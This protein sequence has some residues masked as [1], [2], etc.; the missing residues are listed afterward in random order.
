VSI[1]TMLFDCT[2]GHALFIDN[3]HRVF[4][5]SDVE[6]NSK[7]QMSI[8]LKEKADTP[9]LQVHDREDEAFIR[10]LTKQILGRWYADSI[11]ND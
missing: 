8:S 2:A 3:P 11:L 1:A 6:F 10:D 4:V 9:P 7:L 5:T